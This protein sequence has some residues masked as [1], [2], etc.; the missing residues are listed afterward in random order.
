MSQHRLIISFTEGRGRLKALA[1]RFLPHEEDAEDAVQEAFIRLWTR[2]PQLESQ[3]DS[4][5]LAATTLRNLAIDKTRLR[6]LPTVELTTRCEP[7]APPLTEDDEEAMKEVEEIVKSQ[8]SPLQQEILQLREYEELE[9]DEIANRLQMQP[10]AVRMQL[11]RARKKI[12]EIY[13][14]QQQ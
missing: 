1:R 2:Q 8:L 10:T 12:R 9:Y 6:H 3:Q 13:K 5:R 7:A 14:Q 11:S 4:D